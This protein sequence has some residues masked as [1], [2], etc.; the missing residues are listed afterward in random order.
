MF[1]LMGASDLFFPADK[2]QLEE[3][4]RLFYVAVTRCKQYLTISYSKDKPSLTRFVTELHPTLFT[5][6][7]PSTTYQETD[8]FRQSTSSNSVTSLD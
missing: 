5:F 7:D 4:R 2:V 6:N 1:I 3:E 8:N